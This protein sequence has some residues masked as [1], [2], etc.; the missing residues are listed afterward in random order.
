MELTDQEHLK[1]P[2]LVYDGVLFR[3]QLSGKEEHKDEEIK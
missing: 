3:D 1:N 2:F